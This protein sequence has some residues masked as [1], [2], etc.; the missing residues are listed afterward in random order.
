MAAQKLLGYALTLLRAT[1]D[2]SL[3]SRSCPLRPVPD[4]FVSGK[5]VET[6]D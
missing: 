3:G 4:Q 1:N 6:S 5:S 2:G